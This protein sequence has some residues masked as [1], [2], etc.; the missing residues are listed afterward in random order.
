VIEPDGKQ[1][2]IGKRLS[3]SVTVMDSQKKLVVNASVSIMGVI[4]APSNTNHKS[5]LIPNVFVGS[6]KQY[7]TNNLK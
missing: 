2:S 4:F 6:T 5:S 3:N 1:K 7:L